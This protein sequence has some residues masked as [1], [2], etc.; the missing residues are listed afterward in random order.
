MQ[1]VQTQ[2]PSQAVRLSWIRAALLLIS[3]FVA[4]VTVQSTFGPTVA[5]A[6]PAPTAAYVSVQPCRL[7]DTRLNSGFARLDTLTIQIPARGICG[8]PA[9]ATSVALTLTV[10]RPD[11]AGYLTAWPADQAP[12][13]SNVN[14]DGSQIR[15]NS[16]ITRLDASGN[17]RVHLRSLA[18]RRRC[19]GAFVP[20][21]TSAS[22]RFV[23]RPSTRVFDSRPGQPGAGPASHW[24]CPAECRRTRSPSH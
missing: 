20:A 11:A 7:A 3:V 10:D 5:T 24:R 18:G 16:S 6:A 2:G 9:N 1:G 14:F 15:A 21:T 12:T 23:A 13:V 22:G 4:T 8:I 19:V 17:F